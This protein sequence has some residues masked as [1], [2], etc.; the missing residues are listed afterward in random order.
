MVS[1]CTHRIERIRMLTN[2]NVMREWRRHKPAADR[3]RELAQQRASRVRE[4]LRS[5]DITVTRVLKEPTKSV[6]GSGRI[7][8]RQVG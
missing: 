1:S 2:E 6:R 7:K 3:Q 4:H 5:G 8:V